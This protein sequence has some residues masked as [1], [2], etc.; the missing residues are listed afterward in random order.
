MENKAR[1][2]I[3]GAAAVLVST[4]KLE[5][6]KLVEKYTPEALQ[7]EDENGDPVFRIMTGAHTGTVNHYGIVWGNY[8]GEEGEATV[9]V[10][11]DDEIEDK[12]AAVMDIAGTALLNLIR[13]EESLP[14]VIAEIHEKQKEIETC[15]IME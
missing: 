1:I 13:I 2:H 7:I 9:T 6:W 5:D 3:L 12:K 15:F 8:P 4:V 11:L 14:E 10:L